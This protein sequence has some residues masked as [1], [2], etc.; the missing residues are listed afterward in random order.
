M[1]FVN[2]WVI[3]RSGHWSQ[4]L[5]EVYWVTFIIHY[6]TWYFLKKFKDD[7]LSYNRWLQQEN[8]P[9]ILHFNT[10]DLSTYSFAS[11]NS[12][13][14]C[15]RMMFSQH[16]YKLTATVKVI[17]THKSQFLSDASHLVVNVV[18]LTCVGRCSILSKRNFE[19]SGP[20]ITC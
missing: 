1:Y 6:S 17:Y 16:R 11:C 19:I 12:S 9:C 7:D 8:M 4:S 10:S 5:N 14:V 13:R 15:R 18:G 20:I 3:Q 2:S